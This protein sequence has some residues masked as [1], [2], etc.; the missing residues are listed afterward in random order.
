MD[1]KADTRHKILL[2]GIVV[3]AGAGRVDAYALLGLLVEQLHRFNDPADEQKLRQLGRN[4]HDRTA[5][6][7]LETT[8]DDLA[9]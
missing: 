4:F 9:A 8:H 7:K 3:K 6:A 1:R 2:G 5:R